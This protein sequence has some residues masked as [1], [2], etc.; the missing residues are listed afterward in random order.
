MKIG[1]I[2]AGA[3]G[4]YC[5]ARL[6][7]AGYDVTFIDRG[8]TLEAMQKKGLKVESFMEDLDLRDIKVSAD[9]SKLKDVDFV[10]V[11]VKSF[12]TKDVS[13]MLKPILKEGAAVVSLQNSVE[14]EDVM[15]E[16]LGV[17][18]VIGA[19]VYI[20]CNVPEPGVI[21]HTALNK[22]YFGELDGSTTPRIEALKN[23]F[24]HAGF[25]IVISPNIKRQLWSKLMLNVA[26]NGMTAVM[27]GPLESY[28][29]VTEAH[30]CFFET[31]KEVQKVANLEGYDLT[32]EEVKAAYSF[33][34]S[35][36]FSESTSSTQ[37]DLEAGRPIEVDAIH[38]AVLRA[39]KKHNVEVPY[40]KLLY[41]LIKM[42]SF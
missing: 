41:A 14:N 28:Q 13:E 35:E 30:E 37:S 17:E 36:G 4:G 18:R 9:Y 31:L 38:G 23:M 25:E 39:A 2:G 8:A 21:K 33:T 15:S 40:T 29:K 3:I 7:K 19:A 26:F 42:G 34:T 6:V 20:S 1:V 10:L 27:K 12:A 32:D 11:S 5:G 16:V 24:V 22:L